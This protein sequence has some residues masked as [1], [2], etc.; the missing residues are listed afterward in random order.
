MKNT[1][2]NGWVVAANKMANKRQ[3]INGIQRIDTEE[4]K[5]TAIG[6]FVRTFQRISRFVSLSKKKWC[7]R[8]TATDTH[9]AQREQHTATETTQ[10]KVTCVPIIQFS[11]E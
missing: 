10:K 8:L 6:T 3:I 4:R 9:I 7:G 11:H 1:H 2:F 5:K